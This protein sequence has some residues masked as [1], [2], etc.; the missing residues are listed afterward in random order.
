MVETTRLE[1]HTAIVHTV[2]ASNVG[3]MLPRLYSRTGS[4]RGGWL[5]NPALTA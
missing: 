3:Q 1:G 4:H 2:V 5:I